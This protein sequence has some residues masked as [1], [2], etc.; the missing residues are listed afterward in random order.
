MAPFPF[1][2]LA[3]IRQPPVYSAL[4]FYLKLERIRITMH[5]RSYYDSVL[6]I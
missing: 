4:F 3:D 2:I 1:N 5:R 6:A